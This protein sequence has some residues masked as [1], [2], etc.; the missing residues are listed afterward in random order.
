[1]LFVLQFVMLTYIFIFF[2]IFVRIGYIR[3]PE[4]GSDDSPE[5]LQVEKAKGYSKQLRVLPKDPAK[6]KGSRY[7]ALH[8]FHPEVLLRYFNGTSARFPS[9]VLKEFGKSIQLHKSEK[10]SECKAD[11]DD[12]YYYN[13]PTM[14]QEHMS[15]VITKHSYGS[16]DSF[17]PPIPARDLKRHHVA[18][19]VS[20]LYNT[21]RR[22]RSTT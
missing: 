17:V 2:A 12:D 5:L 3:F 13:F 21:P 4:I 1:M 18:C 20:L 15:K 22:G 19:F 14:A 9:Y 10:N 7:V 6:V 8:H 16:V 11:N